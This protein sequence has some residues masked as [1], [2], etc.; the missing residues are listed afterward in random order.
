MS[1]YDE[2]VDSFII[3]KFMARDNYRWGGYQEEY[4][5]EYDGVKSDITVIQADMGWDCG[6]YSSW[7]RDDTFEITALIKTKYREVKFVYAYWGDF[8]KLI[9]ELDEYM[10]NGCYYESEEYR[11]SDEY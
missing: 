2:A 6:C 10:E 7:T 9:E 11:G 4:N 8:P 1:K 3:D 5:E